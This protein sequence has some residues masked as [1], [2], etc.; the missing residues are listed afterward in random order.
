MITVSQIWS[1]IDWSL[2]VTVLEPNSTPIVKSWVALNLLSVNWRSKQDLPTP[3]IVKNYQNSLE[4]PTMIN[5]NTYE[6]D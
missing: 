3:I 5:L 2:K 4:S 1:F 6:Y